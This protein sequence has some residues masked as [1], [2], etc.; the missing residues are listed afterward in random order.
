MVARS[1][2][3]LGFQLFLSGDIW[4]STAV[5]SAVVIVTSVSSPFSTVTVAELL[6]EAF[7]EPSFGVIL[8]CASEDFLAAASSTCACEVSLPSDPAA[9]SSP[10]EHAESTST[11][12]S[13]ADAA[14]RPL[15]RRLPSVITR[16]SIVARIPTPRG[17]WREP[18]RLV[19]KLQRYDRVIRFPSPTRVG[20]TT[21][22]VADRGNAGQCAD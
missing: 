20:L 21:S 17:P 4:P 12:P 2:W 22:A 16:F 3:P 5:P 11:P 6:M 1:S 8:I 7:V 13:R 10:P 19:H 9:S 15:R 18:R 14:A